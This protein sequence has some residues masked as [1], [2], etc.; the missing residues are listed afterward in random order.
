MLTPILDPKVYLYTLFFIFY[1][2]IIGTGKI[3]TNW[4][5]DI[6]VV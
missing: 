2:V 5:L 6:A 3:A 1:G 4:N